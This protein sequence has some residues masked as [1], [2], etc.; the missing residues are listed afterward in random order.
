LQEYPASDGKVAMSEK[1]DCR[2]DVE[3][4]KVLIHWKSLFANEVA[5]LARQLAAESGRPER[6]TLSDYRQA[7]QIAVHSLSAAI[8][9]GGP[10]RDDRQAA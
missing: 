10:P 3:A 9:D 7:A 6:V 5:V 1:A 4:A 2:I 8:R